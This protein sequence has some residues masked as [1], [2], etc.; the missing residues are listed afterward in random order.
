MCGSQK[1]IS[2]LIYNVNLKFFVTLYLTKNDRNGTR[3]YYERV[4]MD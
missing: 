3:G 2:S 1:T 4:G